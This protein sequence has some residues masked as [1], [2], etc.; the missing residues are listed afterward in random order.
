MKTISADPI[1][2]ALA[3]PVAQGMIALPQDENI[4]LA[5]AVPETGPWNSANTKVWQWWKGPASVFERS[6]FSV[7]S[8]DLKDHEVFFAA[9][10]RLPRQRKEAS[11]VIA[12]CWSALKPGGLLI[13]AAANDA[14]GARLEKDLLPYFPDLQSASKY[15]CRVIWARKENQT[16]PQAWMQDGKL[17]KNPETGF[18]TRP[19]LFSWD[20]IDA[21]TALLL[22][23]LPDGLSGH[24]VDLGCGIGVIADHVLACSSAISLVSCVDADARALA[25]CRQNIEERHP[26]RNV[27]YNWADLSQAQTLPAADVVIMN[28]PFHAEKTTAIALGQSFIGNAASILKPGGSLWMVANAHLPYEQVL[29]ARFKSFE[30][31]HEGKGFK[32]FHA[33]R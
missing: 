33:I 25:A 2:Q 12:S 32:I 24:I 7:F 19:G 4:L 20:R 22:S 13:A 31:K 17:Q 30:K 29:S 15:K 23:H 9:F 28:P 11:F 14:G 6:G 26:G 5:N 18:W 27:H 8:D 16:L 10:V 1:M 3:Y 21:A